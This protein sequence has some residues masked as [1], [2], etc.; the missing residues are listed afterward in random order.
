MATKKKMLQAAAGNA[1]GG[2]GPDVEDVFSTYLYESAGTTQTITNNIDISGEGG[3]V[4]IKRRNGT[5]SNNRLHDT[6]RGMTSGTG[7]SPYLWTNATTG[8]QGASYPGSV[9]A[10]STGFDITS[11]GINDLSDNGGTYASWTFRKAPKFFDVVTYTGDGVAGREMP[12][13]LGVAPGMIIVKRLDSTGQWFSWHRAF[14]DVN[15]YIYLSS[16]SGSGSSTGI[17]GNNLPDS[18]KFELPSHSINA[19]GAT[20]V[21]YLFA[22]NDGDGGFGSDGDADIIKCGS[23]TGNE[24]S[25]PTV[26]LGFEPQWVMIKA[27]TR[28]SN[29]QIFDNMRGIATGGNE[30]YLWANANEPEQSSNDHISL[31]ATGFDLSSVEPSTNST[32]ETFIYIAI[33]RGTKVPE[34][35]TE[36]FDPIEANNSAGTFNTTGFPV[37]LQIFKP[38]TSSTQYWFVNDRLRGVETLPTQTGTSGPYLSTNTTGAEVNNYMTM[39]WDN[40]GFR[41]PSGGF[42]NTDVVYYNW[43][44]A[45]GYFDAVAYTGTGSSRTISHNLGVAPEMIW[46]KKRDGDASWLVMNT[47]LTNPNDDYLVLNSDSSKGSISGSWLTPTSTEFGIGVSFSETNSSGSNYIAYLFASLDGISKVGSYTGTGATLNIDCGFTS[48]ARFVLIR[49]TDAN[50]D[51]M[52]F[53]TERGIVSGNDPFLMLNETS[54]E[55]SGQDLIDPYSSGFTLTNSGNGNVNGSGGSYIFYAIA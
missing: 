36:V 9:V 6:E 22:H 52:L 13:S 19:S 41:T 38:Y 27:A 12:H 2:A 7:G 55:N 10:T 23:Y 17:W 28:T 51:W 33:R 49:R 42:P 37:D 53:D 4:W 45:P 24:S 8:N 47:H 1:G 14:G 39:G 26:N 29:W 3:L 43:K 16:T 35:A 48:G 21:A 34:S 30:N 18:N 20:Y 50:G 46:F 31:N 54:A 25:F 11:T 5:S 44:R 32:G 40:E 15:T